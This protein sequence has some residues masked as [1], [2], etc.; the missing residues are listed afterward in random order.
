MNTEQANSLHRAVQIRS[1]VE[2]LVEINRKV[3]SLSI[4]G[5]LPMTYVGE[6]SPL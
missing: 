4:H 1:L 5:V 2:G 3:Q 6:L